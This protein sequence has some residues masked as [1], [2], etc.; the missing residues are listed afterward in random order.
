MVNLSVPGSL[1]SFDVAGQTT[2]VQLDQGLHR[3]FAVGGGVAYN[4]C[5][6]IILKGGGDNFGRGGA[7]PVEQNHKRSGI[8]RGRIA[9]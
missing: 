1:V 4:D 3:A 7:K 2:R 9:A 5:P 8:K 6:A